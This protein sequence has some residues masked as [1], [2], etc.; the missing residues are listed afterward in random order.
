[1]SWGT[2]DKGIITGR[3]DESRKEYD[4][5][6]CRSWAPWWK[7][8]DNSKK[9]IAMKNLWPKLDKNQRTG[10][11]LALAFNLSF[12]ELSVAICGA[13]NSSQLNSLLKAI[14]NLPGGDELNEYVELAKAAQK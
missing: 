12:P 5:S 13:K 8:M 4:K 7:S 2:L 3:V 14:K 9:F 1:M 6:D 11:E 10:L